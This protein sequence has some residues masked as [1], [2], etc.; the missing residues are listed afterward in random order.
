MSGRASDPGAG[1]GSGSGKR[2][3]PLALSPRGAATEPCYTASPAAS[4]PLP[5][6]GVAPSVPPMY[7]NGNG[8]S[9][10]DAAESLAVGGGS[11]GPGLAEG[12]ASATTAGPSPSSAA[13]LV[14]LRSRPASAGP[15]RLGPAAPS[16]GGASSSSRGGGSSRRFTAVHGA[17]LTQQQPQLLATVAAAVAAA[18]TSRFQQPGLQSQPL[19]PIGAQSAQGLLS[20][21]GSGGG[22]TA[23]GGTAGGGSLRNFGFPAATAAGVRPTSTAYAYQEGDEGGDGEGGESATSQRQVLMMLRLASPG[24]SQGLGLG[25][26]G[27]NGSSP[28]RQASFSPQSTGPLAY[29]GD[30]P[31][32]SADS[33]LS[34]LRQ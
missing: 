13:R 28:P 20:S 24:L 5:L 17:P 19:D 11:P 31:P 3:G 18:Q 1:A 4:S 16:G 2:L 6:Y 30:P 7:G 12:A 29:I 21:G 25:Q 22:G 26:G 34:P 10:G 9:D 23:A 8:T 32:A 14:G 33:R 27:P 15:T